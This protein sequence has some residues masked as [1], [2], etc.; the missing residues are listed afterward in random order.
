MII[1]YAVFLLYR[2]STLPA[3]VAVD[4]YNVV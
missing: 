2:N 4:A 1:F 3:I